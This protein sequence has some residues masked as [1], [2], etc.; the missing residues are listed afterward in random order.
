MSNRHTRAH[1]HS[2][3]RA[4]THTHTHTHTG[5]SE[6]GACAHIAAL[7][8]QPQPCGVCGHTG[9]HR[10]ADGPCLMWTGGGPGRG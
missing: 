9:A 6:G 2:N 7:L 10:G 8:A 3:T 4:H 1:A 5:G